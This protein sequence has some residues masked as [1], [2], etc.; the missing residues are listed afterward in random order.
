MF[1]GCSKSYTGKTQKTLFERIIEHAF[2]DMNSAVYSSINNCDGVK[3]LDNLLKIG[4]IQKEQNKLDQ[5]IY[6][7]QMLKKTSIS[8][9]RQGDETF[10]HL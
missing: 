3:Y 7:E 6:N 4:Q 2:E 10:F 1:P 8:L 5:E 9:V